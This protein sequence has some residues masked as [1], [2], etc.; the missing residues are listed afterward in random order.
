MKT[1]ILV[2]ALI[3]V[4]TSGC[5]LSGDDDGPPSDKTA[6]KVTSEYIRSW[7]T[8]FYGNTAVSVE[9]VHIEIAE[10]ME[11]DEVNEVWPINFDYTWRT[12]WERLP[13]DDY[14]RVAGEFFIYR[15]SGKWRVREN[16][17][18]QTETWDD[19]CGTTKPARP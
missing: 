8:S 17:S 14:S 2:I 1:I 4:T 18:V 11:Y 6:V 16:Q 10:R 7:L 9:V 15:K 12:D 3:A 19:W 13:T 5:V